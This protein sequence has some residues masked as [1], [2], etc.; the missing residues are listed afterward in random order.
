MTNSREKGKPRLSLT[1]GGI[2]GRTNIIIADRE[3]IMRISQGL[4]ILRSS[5]KYSESSA[6][7]IG[8]D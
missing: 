4:P 5:V 3:G 2:S 1:K 7:S 8:K 6:S